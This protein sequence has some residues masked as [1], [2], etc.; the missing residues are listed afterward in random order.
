MFSIFAALAIA[1]AFM[2][3]LTLILIDDGGLAGFARYM[4]TIGV[5]L[6]F[7]GSIAFFWSGMFTRQLLG[8]RYRSGAFHSVYTAQRDSPHPTVLAHK[9]RGLGRE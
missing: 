2:F 5:Y 9:H 8:R 3:V 4:A 6:V 7:I 1:S